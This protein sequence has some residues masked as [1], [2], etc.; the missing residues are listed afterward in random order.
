M[1]R[2]KTTIL[3]QRVLERSRLAQILF[4]FALWLVGEGISRATDIP[5]PGAVLGMFGLLF[6]LT[7][8]MIQLS[9]MRRGAYMLLA[10]MLLFFIPAVLAVLDHKEFLGFVGLKIVAVIVA[11]TLCVMCM[12]ALAVDLGYRVMLALESRRAHA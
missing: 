8:G 4:I 3:F 12:T 5:V 6:L 9:S 7:S 1:S 11:G 10:D 2:R